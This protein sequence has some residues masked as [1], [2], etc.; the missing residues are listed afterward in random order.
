MGPDPAV[1]IERKFDVDDDAAVPL[2]HDL[3]GI[4]RVAQPVEYQLKAE[5]FDTEDFRLA[6]RRI[7]VRR[8]TGGEDA[9]WHLKIPVGPDERHEHH[10]PLG[11][12]GDG[13]PASLLDLVRVH[14]R[15]RALVPVARLS[16]RRI[17][18]HLH[19]EEGGILADLMDDRVRAEVLHPEQDSLHWREWEIELVDGS[20]DLL[21]AAQT[22]V[23]D[24][25]A[26]PA[27]HS[28]KLERT[29][30]PLLRTVTDARPAPTPDGPAADVLLAYLH[31][32]LSAL[33]QQDPQVRRDAPDA[34]HRMRVAT[35]RA[36]SALATYR[37]L[38]EDAD[39]V[40]SLR[41][42][43]KWLAGV[44]GKARDAE[45]M[46][47]RLRE[48]LAGEPA[49]LVLGPVGRRVDLELGGD[50]RRAHAQVLK[51]LRGKRYFRLVDTFESLLTAP[52]LTARAAEPAARLIPELLNR[53]IRRLRSAVHEARHHP[54]GLGDHPALHQARKDAKRLRYGAEAAAPVGRKKITRIADSALGIQK[55]LGE[56]QDSVVTRD[57]LRRLGAAASQQG[58]NGFTYG[59]LHALEQGAALRAEERF[60]KEWKYFPTALGTQ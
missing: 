5:Y 8:R 18:H 24:A 3:P 17:V 58:E 11:R 23:T 29:L 7:T 16:T 33:E 26:R 41:E 46:H 52:A 13:V 45:V 59:R 31:E 36:R 15:D 21:D 4:G 6:A 57:L 25:G 35:R 32:Q 60:R 14:I 42:E 37:S 49:D 54:A 10:A 1:E 48:M 19:G 20:R 56:H 22:R 12:K 39:A 53:D 2:L 51:T 27:T 55:I 30:G 44:L 43:L 40:R 38:L 47:A 34:V 50:Y 9:G 28:S